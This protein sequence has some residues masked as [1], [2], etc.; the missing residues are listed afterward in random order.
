MSDTPAQTVPFVRETMIP[1][2]PAPRSEAGVLHWLRAN[3][4]SGPLNIAL[5]LLGIGAVWLLIAKFGPW[6]AHAV[7]NADSLRE[8]RQIIT[9]RYGE[10]ATGAC[11]AVI[12]HRWNQFLFGFYPRVEYWR[13]TLAFGLLFFAIAPVLFG[14]S[15]R[16]RR[17][18]LAVAAVATFVFCQ[19]LGASGP[20]L[21]LAGGLMVLWVALIE[22]RPRWALLATLVYPFLGVWLLWGGSIWFPAMALMGF[23]IAFAVW[24]LCA[25]LGMIGLA[26]GVVAALIWWGFGYAPAGTAFHSLLPI[27]LPRVPSTQFGGFVLSITIGVAGIAMSLPAGVILA[28][29]RQS[30][31]PVVK[32]LA[33]LFIEFI[34][35]VPLIGMLFVASLLLNYFLPPKVQFD[36]ILRV[37]VMVTIFASAYMAEVVRGGLAALPAGQ[38][39]AANALG[40]DYWKAQRLIILPQALKIAIPSIVSTFIG[41]FKDT[42]LV[43]FVGLYDPLKAMSD[44]VRASFEWKGAYWEPYLFAGAIFFILCFAMARYSLYLERRLKRD[45]R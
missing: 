32:M 30:H 13:P 17:V 35:G 19:I 38:Y 7:W 33:I 15:T 39:E 1:P 31:L 22:Y 4:F 28:L 44:S 12:K 11:F 20:H 26:I 2:A 23:V 34:R 27:D 21:V 37:I 25:R 45:N 9:E 29:A 3:L 10:G 24:R 14:D 41:M 43:T 16:I 18:V 5:T 6:F 36:I 42:T 8:C 40:L